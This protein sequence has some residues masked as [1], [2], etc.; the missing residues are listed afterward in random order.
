MQISS[1]KRNTFRILLVFHFVGIALAIGSRVSDFVID[2]QTADGGLQTLAFGKTLEGAIAR[3][4][5]APGFWLIIATGVAMTVLRYGRRP[6]IWI[7]IKVSITVIGLFVA[8]AFVA[9]A[10]QAAREWARWS[11]E[12]NQLAS[13]FEQSAALASLFGA[14]V[15]TLFLL[16]IPVAVW[17]PFLSVKLPFPG[18]RRE[19]KALGE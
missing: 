17:K 2:Q 13:Q 4:V 10:L 12:H 8:F 19:A 15:F 5:A 6:P 18:R 14:I 16:N 7:W 11:A 9:P 1:R 3:S